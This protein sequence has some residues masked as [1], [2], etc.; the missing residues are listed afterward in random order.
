MT[1]YYSDDL[2][3][4]YHGDCR[5]W[6]PEA[7]VIVTDPPYGI[8]FRNHAQRHTAPSSVRPRGRGYGRDWAAIV[9]DGQSFDPSP[10]LDRP[11]ILWG[12]NHYASRLPDSGGWRVWDKR[13]GGT[14]SPDMNGSHAELAWTNLDSTVRVFSYLWNGYQRDGEVGDHFHP[15]QKPIAL[16][17]WCIEQTT[18][19]VLDPFMGS[20]STLVGAKN[21]GRR[22]I[23]IEIEERYCEIA[24][25]RCAQEVL[26]LVG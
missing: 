2:V 12:A 16:M 3:T 24:A 11:A 8:G 14:V 17:R 26:G 4:I 1:P 15:T 25:T 13:R 19:V 21:A 6:M 7:D 18:G 5:E 23:G 22:A 10:L 20:G 9:G